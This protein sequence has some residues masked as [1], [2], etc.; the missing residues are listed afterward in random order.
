MEL[1]NYFKAGNMDQEIT[2]VVFTYDQKACLLFKHRGKGFN[3]SEL[4]K[5]LF[6]EQT[7]VCPGRRIK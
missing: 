4:I 5:S 6:S 2:K 1:P 7:S 3:I